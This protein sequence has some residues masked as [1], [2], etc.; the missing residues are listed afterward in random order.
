VTFLC[1]AIGI[2][3]QR[4]TTVVW[5]NET[6]KPLYNAI[7]M[8][9]NN[10]QHISYTLFNVSLSAGSSVSVFYSSVDGCEKW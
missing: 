10:C 1:V 9:L 8:S 6:G 3:N 7:G 2:T 4:E 5:D